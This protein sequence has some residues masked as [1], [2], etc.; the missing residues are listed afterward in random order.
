M[1]GDFFVD[2]LNLYEKEMN[3]M[4]DEVSELAAGILEHAQKILAYAAQRDLCTSVLHANAH[5]IE[6]YHNSR[7]W[8]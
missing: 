6:M 5:W 4:Q 1:I 3:Y 8:T 2:I 7:T